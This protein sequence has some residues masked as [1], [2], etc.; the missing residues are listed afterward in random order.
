MPLKAEWE[1]KKAEARLPPL[2]PPRDP[3]DSGNLLVELGQFFAL[4]EER[5]KTEG[6]RWTD[7]TL[8][9]DGI[10]VFDVF[11]NDQINFWGTEFDKAVFA[12]SAYKRKEDD[13]SRTP[14]GEQL[15]YSFTATDNIADPAFYHSEFARTMRDT[16]LY[17]IEQDLRQCLTRYNQAV[18][19]AQEVVE[20]RLRNPRDPAFLQQGPA[21]RGAARQQIEAETRIETFNSS[22]V[23]MQKYFREFLRVQMLYETSSYSPG[24]H[25]VGQQPP[26]RDVHRWLRHTSGDT[27]LRGF[28]NLGTTMTT[29]RFAPSSHM[30]ARTYG[31]GGLMNVDRLKLNKQMIEIVVRPGQL[32]LMDSALVR[33]WRI[34]PT[35]T[36]TNPDGVPKR[37]FGF[38]LLLQ[39]HNDL[40]ISGPKL[41]AENL[42]VP[43]MTS[44]RTVRIFN[45]E[46]T[47]YT[48]FENWAGNTMADDVSE[49]VVA[50]AT[51]RLPL[52]RA[53]QPLHENGRWPRS[54]YP[55]RYGPA[56]RAYT[57]QEMA[58][59]EPQSIHDLMP[60]TAAG[61]RQPRTVVFLEL[62]K[63]YAERARGVQLATPQEISQ[64]NSADVAN[65]TEDRGADA[66]TEPQAERDASEL[67]KDIEDGITP[68]LR[69][70]QDSDPDDDVDDKVEL[71]GEKR[72]RIEALVG[73]IL[74]LVDS[75]P[76]TVS[77]DQL[78]ISAL[79]VSRWIVDA[80]AVFGVFVRAGSEFIFRNKDN[81]AQSRTVTLTPEIIHNVFLSR[82][83]TQ[84]PF[85][86]FVLNVFTLWGSLFGAQ[87]NQIKQKYNI[88][89]ITGGTFEDRHTLGIKPASLRKNPDGSVTMV[90]DALYWRTLFK[91]FNR[92]EVLE[93]CT[94][95]IGWLYGS[96]LANQ[97]GHADVLIDFEQ[98]TSRFLGV[99]NNPGSEL[100][101]ML[102]GDT[103]RKG[104]DLVR[105]ALCKAFS[106][107]ST[108]PA[109]W[110]P[111]IPEQGRVPFVLN[112][113]EVGILSPGDLYYQVLQR[114]FDFSG[115]TKLFRRVIQIKRVEEGL[116]RAEAFAL[117]DDLD[118]YDLE[119][120]PKIEKFAV[121]ARTVSLTPVSQEDQ[122]DF[123]QDN[124]R[125]Q[126]QRYNNF[127]TEAGF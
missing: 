2:R 44:G 31:L 116:V 35:T 100:S 125:L 9:R 12:L 16:V 126:K 107:Y 30:I 33:S 73:A 49:I 26:T 67:E 85:T 37:L 110:L 114:E 7:V 119:Q 121:V 10:Q 28:V 61:R 113:D 59:F 54:L 111:V 46:N 36:P 82:A 53:R 69:R 79:T 56:P 97:V 52:R 23:A 77:E 58:V 47:N 66:R 103:Q 18:V 19:A 101:M 90:L 72:K 55:A 87:P 86:D 117:P 38:S 76:F 17:E 88:A 51:Q 99:P 64:P 14:N 123:L 122:V 106:G 115:N 45:P 41:A 63:A 102:R 83:G 71:P 104:A 11:P 70:Q 74:T 92:E 94:A 120:P 1:T 25:G 32:V 60:F 27:C 5:K 29:V 13:P 50:P 48:N 78:I 75:D 93:L 24:S 4:T 3:T 39:T 105:R 98:W 81:P 21:N 91:L 40:Y 118:F 43:L 68:P 34:R 42:A 57:N 108:I 112:N 6:N 62:R 20:E 22:R 8:L 15:R 95:S 80:N 127:L 65:D 124:G 109:S 84:G 89:G 96:Q